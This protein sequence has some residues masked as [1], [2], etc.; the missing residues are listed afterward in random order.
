MQ[1]L[2][3][4]YYPDRY[5]AVAVPMYG[6]CLLGYIVVIYNAWNLCN[7]NPFESFY[8]IRGYPPLPVCPALPISA[9]VVV[10]RYVNRAELIPRNPTPTVRETT[11]VCWYV[12]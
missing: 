4:T 12:V 3:I 11:D 9:F 7:T 1:A 5:W 2:S 6:M 10:T 8:T